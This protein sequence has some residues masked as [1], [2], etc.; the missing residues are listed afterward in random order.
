MYDFFIGFS[1]A[2]GLIAI[3]FVVYFVVIFCKILLRHHLYFREMD[4]LQKKYE[5]RLKEKVRSEELIEIF[6][7]HLDDMDRVRDKYSMKKK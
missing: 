7:S 6:V 5:Q 3:L 1:R 4:K 2:V